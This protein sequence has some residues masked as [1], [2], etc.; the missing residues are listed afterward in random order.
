MLV[1]LRNTVLETESIESIFTDEELKIPKHILYLKSG[2][3]YYL[4]PDELEKLLGFLRPKKL[5]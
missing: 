4:E 1:E 3:L 5:L 2:K